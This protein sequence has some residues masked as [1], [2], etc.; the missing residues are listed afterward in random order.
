MLG[1]L[2]VDRFYLSLT[3]RTHRYQII[4]TNFEKFSIKSISCYFFLV[5]K[6]RAGEAEKLVLKQKKRYEKNCTQGAV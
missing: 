2:I 4:I 6:S 3:S 1:L 5:D